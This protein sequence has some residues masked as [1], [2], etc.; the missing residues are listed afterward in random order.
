MTQNYTSIAFQGAH[1]AYSDMACRAVFPGLNTIPCG[2]FD[3][4][5]N[6]VTEGQAD[7]AMIPVDN[8]IAGRVADVHHLMPKG[9]LFIIGEHFL[10]F[11]LYVLH[12]V[13]Q[14]FEKT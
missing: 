12:F 10:P 6:V 11:A 7:L 1:G 3:D 4:V 8:T 2:S 14:G 5:F 9:D 13:P